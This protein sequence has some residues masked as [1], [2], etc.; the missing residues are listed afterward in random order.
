MG[1]GSE[2][3]SNS[4]QYVQARLHRRMGTMCAMYG[5]P[6]EA[7]AEAIDP[8]S[9][10]LR[11]TAFQ[12]RCNGIGR[13]ETEFSETISLT[14]LNHTPVAHDEADSLC[15]SSCLVSPYYSIIYI[16]GQSAGFF[17]GLRLWLVGEGVPPYRAQTSQAST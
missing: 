14:S 12:R 16:S 9:R 10:T 15:S 2:T 3:S 7:S 1:T 6:V 5:C 8:T 11:V 4:L 13:R 17:N